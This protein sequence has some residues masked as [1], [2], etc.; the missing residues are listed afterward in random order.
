MILDNFRER[1][2]PEQ[3]YRC[4]RTTWRRGNREKDIV[5]LRNLV[6]WNQVLSKATWVFWTIICQHISASNLIGSSFFFF[7][8][9]FLNYGKNVLISTFMIIWNLFFLGAT[10]HLYKRVCPSV[11]PSVTPS[12]SPSYRGVLE[13]L[14]SCIR[15][16]LWSTRKRVI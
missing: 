12:D 10:K 7:V 8:S 16:C 5:F 13:H 4:T 15:P 1:A 3:R 9:F 6:G 2:T 14:M 11:R